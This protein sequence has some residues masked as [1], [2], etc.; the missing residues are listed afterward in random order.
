MQ[1]VGIILKN[2]ISGDFIYSFASQGFTVLS[3]MKLTSI[4]IVIRDNSGRIV[5]LNENNSIIFKITKKA[6]ESIIDVPEP[7]NN[8]P[9]PT[10]KK[11]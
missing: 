10:R 8:P 6:F 3:P 9:S 11:K 2:Y 1:V 7:L 4:K 5:S